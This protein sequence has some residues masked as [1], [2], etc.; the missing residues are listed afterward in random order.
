[1]ASTSIIF[2]LIGRDKASDKFDK[3]GNSAERSGGKL[4]KM[5]KLGKMAGLGLAA[6]V[7]AAAV[8]LFKLA[9]GAAED[10]AGQKRLAKAMQ[11]AAGASKSQVAATEDWIT[12]QGKALGV[13]DDQLRPALQNLV[14]ATHDVGKAQKLAGLAMD[15]AAGKNMSLEMVSKTLAKA[16]NGN[17][18]ALS[19]LGISTKDAEGK[20]ISFAE[21]QKR[22]SDLHKGQASTAANTTAGKYARL[23][24]MLS[25]T[26]ETIGSKLLPVGI[27]LADW[28]IKKG[29]PALTLFG[30]YLGQKLPPIFTKVRA[31]VSSVMNALSGDVGGNLAKVKGIFQNAV[32]IVQSLWKAFG[33]NIVQYL[34]ATFENV[35]MVVSG[36]FTVISGIFKTVSALLK[37]D[38]KGVWAGIKQIVRGGV[39]IVIGLVRQL[40]NMV[41]FAFKNLGVAAK[42]IF[43]SMWDGVKS[44]ARS[45]ASA[46]VDG[47]KAIPGKIKGAGKAFLSAG[48][49]LIGKLFEG[50]KSAASGAGGLAADL[51]GKLKNA[52]NS[53]LHLPVY[54]PKIK[55]GPKSFGPWK[56]IPAFARGGIA[57]GGTALVGEEGPELVDLPGGSKVTPHRQSMARLSGGGG[58]DRPIVV[59]F[60]LDGKVIEQSL[61]KRNRQTGRPLQVRTI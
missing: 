30:N 7:G 46:V 4:A 24:L 28:F 16:Q 17:V 43:R 47:I 22:L 8:G 59:Q 12:A 44:L 29:V 37:G 34:R 31:V 19:K 26:G 57:P 61:I 20:T 25:E 2:D 60:V 50:F 55:I 54:T 49:G 39:Q 21:A 1:M 48:K 41:R 45:G 15:V 6:G 52:L 14:G 11:N 18:G 33:A 51:A 58:D 10:E 36:A 35:K 38:W 9:Q 56:V 3:V 27:K 32:S 42:A 40:G 23:K 5:G 13:A 53:G